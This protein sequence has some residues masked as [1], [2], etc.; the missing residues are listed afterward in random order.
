M[1]E[2]ELEGV[3]LEATSGLAHRSS[4]LGGVFGVGAEDLGLN[5]L[6]GGEAHEGVGAIHS[7]VIG[8]PL[9]HRHQAAHRRARSHIPAVSEDPS[10]DI[11]GER[12]GKGPLVR[13]ED[14]VV[15]PI[16][17]QKEPNC[18]GPLLAR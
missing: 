11:I 6:G 15:H 13:G 7:V 12:G 9:P 3:S 4:Q 14:Q 18:V 17:G 10:G 1:S 5:G 2:L 16:P 8:V